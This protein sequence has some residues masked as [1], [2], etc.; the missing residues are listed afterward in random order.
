MRF[1]LS[2]KN[3]IFTAMTLLGAG[4]APAIKPGR[5]GESPTSVS[6]FAD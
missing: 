6:H 3:L 4:A 2:R 5:F 1:K